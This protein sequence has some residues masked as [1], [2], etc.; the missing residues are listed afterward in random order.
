MSE[1][2]PQSNLGRAIFLQAVWEKAKTSEHGTNAMRGIQTE[3]EIQLLKATFCATLL[4]PKV[5]CGHDEC[6]IQII[7]IF[8]Q[9]IYKNKTLTPGDQ[10]ALHLIN[11]GSHISDALILGGMADVITPEQQEMLESL[12]RGETFAA[13]FDPT[14]VN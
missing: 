13:S 2:K 8:T 3:D 7:D 6:L 11:T 10:L 14:M 12:N 1:R 9:R 5:E 4:I